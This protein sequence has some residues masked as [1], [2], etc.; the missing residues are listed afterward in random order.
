MT[1]FRYFLLLLSLLLQACTT[2]SQTPLVDPRFKQ[3]INYKNTLAVDHPDHINQVIHLPDNFK[4]EIK[5]RFGRLRSI[6][7]VHKMAKWLISKDGYDLKYDIDANLT[8][9]EALEQRRGNCLTFTLLIIELA[10]SINITINANQ[11]DLPDVWGENGDEDLVFYRHVNGIMKKGGNTQI[12]DLAIQDYNFA[13]PQRIISQQ[14]SVALLYSNKGVDSLRDRNHEKARHYLKLAV[15]AFPEN[16][17]MW[18]NYG[19]LLK[20]NN[21]YDLAEASFLHALKL[22]DKNNLAA[23]NLERLYRV[24][25][26]HKKAQLYAKKAEQARKRNPY[27]LFKIAKQQFFD[28]HSEQALNTINRSIRFHKKD[29]RFFALRSMIHQSQELYVKALQDLVKATRVSHKEDDINRY[30]EEAKMIIAKLQSSE[31]AGV[32]KRKAIERNTSKLEHYDRLCALTL[33]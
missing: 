16:P 6:D 23:S 26:Q 15:S 27:Y 13:Y 18:I 2:T 28:G 17:D 30:Q 31:N 12:L 10:K 4:H 1:P 8:P 19:A 3:L 24:L 32:R 11:V 7:A 21:E 29:H 14:Q 5:Q 33:C 9:S 20:A 22:R 25:E